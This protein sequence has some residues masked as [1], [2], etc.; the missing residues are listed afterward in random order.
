M[1][2]IQPFFLIYELILL[3]FGITINI[4]IIK[5]GK[6]QAGEVEYSGLLITAGVINLAVLVMGLILPQIEY[7]GPVDLDNLS[8]DLRF[9]LFYQIATGLF[10]TIPAVITSGIIFLLYGLKN[11]EQFRL[12]LAIAGIFGIIGSL[13]RVLVLNGN[14]FLIFMT[15]TDVSMLYISILLGISYI[16]LGLLIIPRTILIILHGIRNFDS[17]LKIAGI[18]SLIQY[19]ATFL[20]YFLIPVA[21]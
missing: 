12:Y 3:G 10:L 8:P 5:S 6:N 13:L 17:D 7:S 11:K 1:I 2:S 14:L 9:Y 4:Y 21:L 20:V 15:L 19:V 18:I 16:L